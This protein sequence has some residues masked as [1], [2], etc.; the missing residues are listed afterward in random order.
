MKNIMKLIIIKIISRYYKGI[1]RSYTIAY[2]IYL[3][4][5]IFVRYVSINFQK[6][7]EENYKNIYN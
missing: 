1:E 2:L 7:Q 6:K 5:Y 4:I 3:M